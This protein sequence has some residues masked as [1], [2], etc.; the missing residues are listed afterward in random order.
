MTGIEIF[1]CGGFMVIAIFCM[2]FLE[3]SGFCMAG[4]C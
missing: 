3:D 4:S 1:F 2:L